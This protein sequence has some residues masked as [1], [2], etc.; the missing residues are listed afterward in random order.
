MN[1]MVIGI[2][3]GAAALCW[4]LSG[5]DTRL[6]GDDRASDLRRRAI[7][8]V[9]TLL[10]MAAGLLNALILLA[11]MVLIAVIWTGCV[12]EL[13]ARGFHRI[14]DSDDTRPFDSRQAARDLDKLA[15]LVQR[16]RNDEAIEWCKKLTE[17]GEAS[18]LAIEAVLFQLYSR[19][20]AEDRLGA[21]A[22]LSEAQ[23]FRARNDPG[24]AASRLESI[25]RKE[26]D[27]L[28]ATFL[29]MRILAGDLKQPEK[30]E[31]LLQTLAQRPHVPP[32][33]VEYARGAIQESSGLRP[34][35]EQTTE[36]IESLLVHRENDPGSEGPAGPG[37][38]SV[39]ELLD[40]GHLA[41][42]VELLEGQI[43][44]EPGNWDAWLKLAEAH[45]RYCRNFKLA[46]KVVGRIESNPAFSKEQVSLAKSKL[47]E[48]QGN[49]RV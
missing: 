31:A 36:G 32:V 45:G 41:T 49:T 10:L 22:A 12:S 48:W 47:K 13:A 9:A 6:T 44:D 35:K 17:S 20:F 40:S 39:D 24:K 23:E 5:Y 33:F 25:L 15:L 29:L 14:V 27:N 26:P 46:A 3:A 8:C 16:G 1:P 38:A 18:A 19:M 37:A 34:R 42:A 4:W 43:R 2:F 30:A 7:R 11:V 21:T 28:R